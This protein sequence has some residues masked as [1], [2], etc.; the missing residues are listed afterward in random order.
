[1]SVTNVTYHS[2]L[3]GLHQLAPYYSFWQQR[4]NLKRGHIRWPRYCNCVHRGRYPASR[5]RHLALYSGGG[6]S[7]STLQRLA[8]HQCVKSC[9]MHRLSL[10]SALIHPFI[11]S[12]TPSA[13]VLYGGR[14]SLAPHN[15]WS[16][17][18]EYCRHSAVSIESVIPVA[19]T[20]PRIN[21]IIPVISQI[22]DFYLCHNVTG[23]FVPGKCRARVNT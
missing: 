9:W 6:A 1:M 17:L 8:G 20:F 2:V 18:N 11:C 22:C 19:G 10:S 14:A 21:F 23:I 7:I 12:P 3:R 15:N 13:I 16:D 4:R 5:S